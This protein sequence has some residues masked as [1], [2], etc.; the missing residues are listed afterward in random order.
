VR[1]FL[2]FVLSG[3]L[4]SLAH[5][6]NKVESSRLIVPGVKAGAITPEMTETELRV[7]FGEE[8]VQPSDVDVGEGRTEHGT[9]IYPDEPARKME[10]LWKDAEEKRFPKRLIWTGD[11]TEWKTAEGISLGTT[12]KELERVNGK[13]FSF[14]GF[15]WDYG[16]TIRSWQGGKLKEQF[17]RHGRIILRLEGPQ[18]DQ[19]VTQEEEGSIRG[20][21]EL[22][23]ENPIVRKFNPKIYQMIMEFE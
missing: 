7:L 2:L 9:V 15:G 3:L 16:G 4:I 20:N 5:A 11:R 22:T 6:D 23:S 21:R 19:A 17:Y 18:D 1:G 13:P 14:F 10:I 12:L 8:N